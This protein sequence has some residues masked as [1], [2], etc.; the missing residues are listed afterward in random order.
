[1]SVEA[2][3]FWG[4]VSG[5]FST[6][7]LWFCG[8][9]FKTVVIPTYQKASYD[10][11][12]LKGRWTR[13]SE[14]NGATYTYQIDIE[15]SAHRVSGTAVITKS[16]SDSDYIQDFKFTGETWEGYLTVNM[17]SSTNVS[18]SFVSGLFKIEDRGAVL[19]GSWAYRTRDDNVASE[20][21]ALT[22]TQG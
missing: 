19:R 3:V 13:V 7:F 5:V 8:H 17:R 16:N 1:M 20:D 18:L 2:T 9:V 4:A 14:E 12:D 15:Q 22:R 11:V 21:F 6:V 10:G